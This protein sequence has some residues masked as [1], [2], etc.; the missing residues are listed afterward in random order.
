[1]CF[2][3]S[4]SLIQAAPSWWSAPAA[5]KASA[6]FH[7]CGPKTALAVSSLT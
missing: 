5:G 4:M 3:Y 7:L 1:M 6:S 2:W